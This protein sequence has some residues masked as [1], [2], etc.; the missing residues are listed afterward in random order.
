MPTFSKHALTALAVVTWLT[1]VSGRQSS[2]DLVL[3]KG[4]IYTSNA[5]HP[6][7][8]ALAIQ[9]D[10]ILAI[11]STSEILRLASDHSRRIDLAGRTVIPGIND[12]H[13]HLV[14]DLDNEYDL[15]LQGIDLPGRKL[16]AH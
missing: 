13:L 3:F 1:M 8:E 9:G 12:A 4:R 2:P 6:Y 16:Q 10:R 7:A 15:P 5:K 11:G 14:V